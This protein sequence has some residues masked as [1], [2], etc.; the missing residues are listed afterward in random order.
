VS[1]AGRRAVLIV[2]NDVT[3]RLK[4]QQT[5][6]DNE[7]KYR[8]L[9][10]AADVAIILADAATGRILEANRRAETLLGLPRHQIVGLPS[11][12]LAPPELAVAR[13]PTVPRPGLPSGSGA[14]QAY[15]WHRAGR[16]IPVDVITSM[17]EV[18][19]RKVVQTIYRDVTERKRVEEA[20]ARRT[21]QL[22]VL[23]RANRH[24]HAVLEVP[25]VL[26][27]LVR[28]A[29][30][31][32]RATG[33]MAGLLLEGRLVFREYQ[34]RAAASAVDLRF[35]PG[36]G[37]AGYVLSS[38]LSY[39]SNDP[40]HD[41]LVIPE[42]QATYQLRNLVC[43]PI[44]GREGELLGCLEVHNTENQRAVEESDLTMLEVLAASAATAIENARLLA[45]H[46][47]LLEAV[48]EGILV[49]D[50]QGRMVS[51]NQ[52][53]ARLWQIPSSILDLR[54]DERAL[55][56]V[57][58]QLQDPQAF[59]AKVKQL[60]A[61][62]NAD[63]HDL[64]PFKDGRVFERHSR[65]RWVEGRPAGRVW[66]FRDVTAQLPVRPAAAPPPARPKKL[67]PAPQ[68]PQP[69]PP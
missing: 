69:P 37:V 2:A 17:I 54:Q 10:E 29:L 67:R 15:V 26:H 64:I 33:G 66:S 39:S 51:Y 3:E 45:Q 38:K 7:L 13:R 34:T 21:Q 53:F 6:R 32:V 49:V 47:A 14:T 43:V 63:S 46:A 5:L 18:G 55:E 50:E 25:A 27:T 19:G 8:T 60:Y 65:P 42:L 36:Q 59:L 35:A 12:E 9:I 48:P 24:L 1:F 31:M 52:S 41:P 58:Q 57:L 20:L 11:Q 62:P 23:A 16:R 4:A 68:P 44:L 56:F 40:A 22:E 28:S 30:D 61:T